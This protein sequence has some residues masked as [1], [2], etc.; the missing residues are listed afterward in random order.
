[1]SYLVS[2]SKKNRRKDCSCGNSIW[3]FGFT[4]VAKECFA[5]IT[6]ESGWSEE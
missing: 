3:V 5:F 2:V 6:S 1:M 4:I